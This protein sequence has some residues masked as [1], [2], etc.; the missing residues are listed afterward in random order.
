ML[1]REF[2]LNAV[3]ITE[4]V[5]VNA[6]S[7]EQEYLRSIETDRLL[8]GFRETAGL[9]KKAERYPGGWE[10]AEIAGHTLG[11]YMTALAQLYAATDAEDIRERLEYILAE[12]LKCQAENG[13]LFTSGEEIFDRL[14]K[15]GLSWVP[16]YTMHKILAGLISVYQLAKLSQALD[17]AVK[18]GDWTY[19][20]VMNWTEKVQKNV[21]CIEY[22]GM[23]DCLYELYRETG[24]KEFAEAAAKFDETELFEQIAEG[25]DVLRN[26]HANTTIPKFL[27]A[28]NRYLALGESE[29]FYLDAAKAFFDMVLQNH[30]Y[31]TGGNSEWEHFRVPGELGANRTQ[32]NCE[33][34]N[35]YNMLKLAERLYSVTGEKRYM[36]YYERTFMNAI[37]GSQNPEDGMTTYFQPMAAGYFKT[38][39]SPFTKFWCCTGTSMENFTKL[40][41]AIYHTAENTLYVNLYIASVLRFEELGLWLTQTVDIN[42]FDE[43]SFSVK[44]DAPKRFTLALRLPEWSAGDADVRINGIVPEYHV[45][46]GYLLLEGSWADGEQVVLTLKPVV[47]LHPLPDAPNSAAVTYGPL[48]LAAGLGQE[49]MTTELTGVN[50]TVPTKKIPVRE[51]IVLKD[52]WRLAEWFAACNENFVKQ[53]D[54]LSFTLRGT[55]A[56]EE[57]VFRPY[58]RYYKERYGI[59]FDYY[60]R[61][62]LP[63]DL[64]KEL[65]E[66]KRLEEER[67]A[68]EAAEAERIRQE[69][70]EA[71]R[72]RR[73]EEKRAAE[74]KA[75]L[76]AEAAAEAERMA[77]AAAEEEARRAEE[78]AKEA[79]RQAAEAAA[80]EER[81]RQEAEEAERRRK[82]EE[83]LA[84]IRAAEE[85][86]AEEARRKE[87]EALLAAEARR[88]AAQAVAD[89]E[90]EAELAEAKAREEEASLQAAKYAAERAEAEA[91][92]KKAKAEAEEADRAAE[93]AKAAKAEETAKLDKARKSSKRSIYRR[94]RHGLGAVL[95]WIFGI[96][97]A[98][99]LLYLFATPVSKGF[100]TVKDAVD[101]F[102]AEKFPKVAENLGIKGDGD[103]VPVFKDTATT[104]H[105]VENAESFV[106]DTVWPEGY[107]AAVVRL[108]GKQYICIEGNGLKTYYLNEAAENES[109][110]V[111]LETENQKALYFWNYSFDNPEV[112]CPLHG[113]FNS[114]DAE[115]Y[116]F[117][118]DAAKSGLHVL[119]AFT[120]EN[121][122]LIPYEETVKEALDVGAYTEDEETVRIDMT[123][124]GV[125]YAFLVP[126]LANTFVPEE[127]QIKLEDLG[128]TVAEEGVRFD[129][130]VVSAGAYLGKVVGRM[131][132]E[133]QV[134]VLNQLDFYAYAEEEYGNVSEDPVLPATTLENAAKERVAVVGD[135]GERLLIPV[136]EDVKRYEYDSE[137]FI[138][139]SNGE[140]RYIQ[141]GKTVSVK[142]V[143]VSKYQEKIDW[144][145]VAASGV[146]YAMIRLGFRGMGTKGT[147][148]LDSYYKRNVQG[149]LDAGI[150][151]G[152]YFFSQATTVEEAKEEAQFVLE[153]IKEYDV[154]W[155]VAYDTE[156]ITSYDAARANAISRE[157]RTA[158]AKA[159]LDE[160]AAA[161]YTPVL[162]ANTRWS[163]LKLDL[164]QLA[165]YDLWYAYYGT[166]P[167]YP[168]HYTMWQYTNSGK[169]PGINGNADVNISFV[170]YG[171]DTE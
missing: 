170:D 47:K 31:V 115:Q 143:D 141:D 157:E 146:K 54:A 24:R 16:W 64:Q 81:R 168:Y 139:E 45:K 135:H 87:E 14:E 97:L 133:N 149:A 73:E 138:E 9:E 112:L 130:Y 161:G 67:L 122:K 82:E 84:A 42:R 108:N 134:Y 152:V 100:F 68:A 159:F 151:V 33:T 154:T 98:V 101:T 6:F 71:E 7:K 15:G 5:L 95:A 55:D 109:K 163:L 96:L 153:H 137:A 48:V 20:R 12:L 52:E 167:Y 106:N 86:A 120:L 88:I 34:C 78:A 169:I 144:E 76:E 94:K 107:Q 129:A 25:N 132:Y 53:D 74:E 93:A 62:N 102:V 127:Y 99:V 30:T 72:I 105:F 35:T 147:C 19:A 165:G 11:H 116:A 89:A 131:N 148:E 124:A 85:A 136:R 128:Y 44:L 83:E 114:S 49:D 41:H 160:I 145:K 69:A 119:D 121:C 56:D 51:R 92:V 118:T 113:K 36:D 50:V 164:G 43:V 61:D 79:E 155:P 37:L 66:K 18:L 117:Y 90:R 38:F 2:A 21:L 4:P 150:E 171:A 59:Y 123:V 40:N 63:E 80:E 156:E 27:G 162:Y 140:I 104:V 32:C 91:V 28:L 58:Y 158:C 1:I 65:E 111:Y 23:N 70:E 29:R 60:D 26:K 103:A 125:P 13:Y 166:A 3:E 75:R 57:L 110:H 8:A 39:S 17:I 77:A 46:D 142:G 22:G 126:K 10:N